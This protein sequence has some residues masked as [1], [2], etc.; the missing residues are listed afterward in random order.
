MQVEIW[1]LV[2]ALMNHFTTEINY[3]CYFWR[4]TVAM[5]DF[6]E[7]RRAGEKKCFPEEVHFFTRA[8]VDKYFQSFSEPFIK[9]DPPQVRNNTQTFK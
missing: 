3:Q 6:T 9:C 8:A 2:G 7:A 4:S 1:R 5:S